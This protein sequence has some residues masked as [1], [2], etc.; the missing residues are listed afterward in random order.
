MKTSLLAITAIAAFSITACSTVQTTDNTPALK[1]GEIHFPTRSVDN[2][3]DVALTTIR[4]NLIEEGKC[5]YLTNV[6]GKSSVNKY[7]VTW[8]SNSRIERQQKG[9]GTQLVAVSAGAEFN[10]NTRSV[11]DIPSRVE[12]MG[13]LAKVEDAQP[14]TLKAQMVRDCRS[15]GIARVR[16]WKT[17]GSVR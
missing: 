9:S 5:L 10:D 14:G 6:T 15:S 1:A 2:L 3:P 7:V 16:T 17:V 4:G 8:P 11:A 12:F 13:I